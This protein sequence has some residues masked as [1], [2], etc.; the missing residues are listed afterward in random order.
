MFKALCSLMFNP[1][2]RA[3][4]GVR[5]AAVESLFLAMFLACSVGILI[6]LV[7]VLRKLD[8]MA[9]GAQTH[10]DFMDAQGDSPWPKAAADL[11]LEVQVDEPEVLLCRHVLQGQFQGR[12]VR[13]QSFD[14]K[15]AGRPGQLSTVR[16]G[17]KQGM[18]DLELSLA[19]G[20]SVQKVHGV[21]SVCFQGE[22]FLGD[23]LLLGRAAR[24]IRQDGPWLELDGRCEPD[25]LRGWLDQALQV[26]SEMERAHYAPWVQAAQDHGLRLE[27]EREQ[28]LPRLAGL[29]QGVG[30]RVSWVKGGGARV[31]L[32][33]K[34]G[35]SLADFP[36][37]IEG[38][39]SVEASEDGVVLILLED[40]LGQL[41]EL[42]ARA[43]SAL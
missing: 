35:Q 33:C 10:D 1:S 16:V 43:F 18:P 6:F 25:K 19:S 31:F 37:E 38:A 9:P 15:H 36:S 11:G 26:F 22:S 14:R 8:T 24:P 28:R 29:M 2:G 42:L 23:G 7:S 32:L 34:S 17:V 21:P 30:V 3:L 40:Q 39:A 13:V 27:W 41:S 12:L 20:A 5:G 4:A